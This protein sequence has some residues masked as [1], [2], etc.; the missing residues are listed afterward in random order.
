[1]KRRTERLL[2]IALWQGKLGP[3]QTNNREQSPDP[4]H[5]RRRES[6]Q[7]SS[8]IDAACTVV[9]VNATDYVP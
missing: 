4:W 9:L 2:L 6:W 1:M 3:Q 7:S 5:H 8:Q